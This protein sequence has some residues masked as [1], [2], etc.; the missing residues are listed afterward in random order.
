LMHIL[1]HKQY[2][3][4]VMDDIKMVKIGMHTMWKTLDNHK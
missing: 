2:M 3:A 1:W 4:Y